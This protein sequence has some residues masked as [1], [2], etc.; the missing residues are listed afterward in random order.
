[1]KAKEF[2][3]RTDVLLRES[4]SSSNSHTNEF[5][6]CL[7]QACLGKIMHFILNDTTLKKDRGGGHGPLQL[8]LKASAKQC[9]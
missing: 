7:S 9:E 8:L 4:C 2:S 5:A 3:D 6:L 1:V